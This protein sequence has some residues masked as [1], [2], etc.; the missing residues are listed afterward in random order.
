[1]PLSLMSSTIGASRTEWLL[2]ALC[3]SISVDS[4]IPQINMRQTATER[5]RFQCILPL[6]VPNCRC[7]LYEQMSRDD[8]ACVVSV[9]KKHK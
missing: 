4:G 3:L 1:M 7:V 8:V 2:V 5:G 6:R 9:N